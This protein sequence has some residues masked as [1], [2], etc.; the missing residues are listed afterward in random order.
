[1]EEQNRLR[2]EA[3]A[4]SQRLEEQMMQ[5]QQQLTQQQKLVEWMAQKMAC[6]DAHLTVSFCS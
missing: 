2:E 3:E 5:Q 4:K 6:Y 1:V